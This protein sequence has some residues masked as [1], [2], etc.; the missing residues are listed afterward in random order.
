MINASELI[1]VDYN[2]DRMQGELNP[3]ERKLLYDTVMDNKIDIVIEVGTSHGGGSTYALSSA[4]YN[5]RLIDGAF[6][7]MITIENNG[8]HYDFA[9]QLYA[10]EEFSRQ[11][12]VVDFI[13]ADSTKY[14]INL[15]E[16]QLQP[17]SGKLMLFLDGGENHNTAVYDYVYGKLLMKKG[18]IFAAHDF[19]DN[20][21]RYMK[22]LINDDI[23]YKKINQVLQLAIFE[24]IGD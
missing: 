22:P 7:H 15:Y 1:Q 11:Q 6:T 17:L 24:R 10:T 20:K 3:E 12:Q 23:D 13:L 18:D 2:R 16:S 4:L 21:C 19:D 9:R 14:I 8:G 5:R